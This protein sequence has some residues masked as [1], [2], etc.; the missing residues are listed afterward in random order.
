MNLGIPCSLRREFE[1]TNGRFLRNWGL[2]AGIFDGQNFCFS[3]LI[4][5]KQGNTVIY[6]RPYF[7]Q[8]RTSRKG[9][10]ETGPQ[11]LTSCR[12][13]PLSPCPEE[14]GRRRTARFSGWTYSALRKAETRWRRRR[15]SNPRYPYEYGSLAGSWFQ[16]LTHVSASVA[17]GR[18]ITACRGG[19]KSMCNNPLLS[20]QDSVQRVS[21]SLCRRFIAPS[22]AVDSM[23]G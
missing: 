23:G 18:P 5:T 3:L 21:D 16:P 6:H 4:R 10:G 7:P 1:G 11:S 14:P 19:G 12:R 20:A 2:Y 8:F 22:A 15:D 17:A 13:N 9:N